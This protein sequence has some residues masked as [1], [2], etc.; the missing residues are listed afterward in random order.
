MDCAWN[1]RS[2]SSPPWSRWLRSLLYSTAR[3]DLRAG[4]D[5]TIGKRSVVLERLRELG[6]QAAKTESERA[7]RL[8]NAAVDAL[9]SFQRGDR[10]AATGALLAAGTAEER[11]GRLDQ[12]GW[13]YQRAAQCARDLRIR[14]PETEAVLRLG[15]LDI[16]R[17]RWLDAER[18]LGR[19]LVL[20]NAE[21]DRLASSQ[22][23]LALGD[24]GL[25]RSERRAAEEWYRRG[26]ETVPVDSRVRG[27]LAIGLSRCAF[28][29]GRL[30]DAELI[31]LKA[32]PA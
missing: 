28:E 27:P 13:W 22:A 17:G 5:G 29:D 16:T 21:G 7:G 23:C 25:A 6:T 8:C 30:D 18:A 4:R 2:S 20:A 24:L 10:A 12:A 3:E 15:R 32:Q 26:L 31:L 11:E 1:R 19:C 14:S 9:E